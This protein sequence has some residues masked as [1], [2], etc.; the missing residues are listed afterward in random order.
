MSKFKTQTGDIPFHIPGIPKPASTWYKLHTDPSL[1]HPTL[2]TIHGGPGAGHDYLTPLLDLHNH[3]NLPLLFY[4][5]IGSGKSTHFRDKQKNQNFWTL[6]LYVRELD[7]LIEQLGLQN[8]RGFFLLG[9]SWGGVVASTYAARQPRGLKKLIIASGPADINLYIKGTRGLLKELQQEV[10]ETIEECEKKGDYTSPK[11]EVA[12]A[13]FL[14]RHVC[15]LGT[16][17]QDMLTAFANL[18]DDPTAYLTL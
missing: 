9:H 1:P 5:S 6:D 14:Q 12:K 4:D 13:V 3:H 15:R 16:W 8:G 11:Y 17:P 2:I 18:G 10:R 7:N